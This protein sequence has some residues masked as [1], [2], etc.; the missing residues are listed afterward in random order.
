VNPRQELE[1]VVYTEVFAYF[2]EEN[3]LATEIHKSILN[4]MD[5]NGV[6]FY[7]P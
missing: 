1:E 3:E 4:W 7:Q 2:G 5:R 6:I